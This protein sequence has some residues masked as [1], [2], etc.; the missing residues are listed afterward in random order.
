MVP[1]ASEPGDAERAGDAEGE[2][3]L[4]LPLLR[5]PL[6]PDELL[7]RL[8]LRDE[9]LLLLPLLPDELL[10]LRLPLRDERLLRLPLR[11]PADDDDDTEA[12]H[13]RSIPNPDLAH[14]AT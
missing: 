6:L 4:L 9:R 3:A 7:L 14:T 1:T 8:L 13:F 5:L 12:L 11:L 10:R 2:G